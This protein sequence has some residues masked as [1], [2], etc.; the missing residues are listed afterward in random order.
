MV[1]YNYDAIAMVDNVHEAVEA[2][3]HALTLPLYPESPI[4]ELTEDQYS[5]IVR[6][7]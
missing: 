7:T 4:D 5:K 3:V 2:A 1:D 6:Y